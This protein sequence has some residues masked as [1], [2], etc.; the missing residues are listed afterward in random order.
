MKCDDTTEE[1]PKLKRD[2]Q[3]AIG[4]VCYMC[5]L[6]IEKNSQHQQLQGLCNKGH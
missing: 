6:F 3:L 1:F 2:F 4:R 5:I